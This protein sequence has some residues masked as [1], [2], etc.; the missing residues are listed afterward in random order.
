MA[1]NIEPK[2]VTIGDYLKLERDTKFVIPEYQ[3]EYSWDITTCDKLWSDIIDFIENENNDPYFFG[4]IIINCAKEDTEFGLIDGQQRTTTFMLLLKALLVR[5]NNTLQYMVNDSENEQIKR[6][7]RERRRNLTSILYKVS[8]DEIS[9]EPNDIKDK[10][11]YS[12]FDSVINKSNQET[13]SKELASIMTS[14]NYEEA[15]NNCEKDLSRHKDNRYTNYF[16]N[17]KHFY[18]KTELDKMD[19]LNKIVKTILEKCQ[20]IEIKSWNVEQAITMFNSL[21]SDGMPLTDSDI[22][23]SKMFASTASDGEREKLGKKWKNLIEITKELERNRIANISALLSQKMYLYRSID[24]DTKTANGGTDVT[25][26]GLRRYYTSLKPELIK[27][28]ISFC[29][30]LI[31]LANIWNIVKENTMV[32]VLLV[33][34]DNSKL[35]LASYFHRFDSL[36]TYDEKGEL[37]ITKENKKKI[38]EDT[39]EMS[40]PLLK[41]FTILSLVDYGYSSSSFKTFLFAEEIKMANSNI[42]VEEI[43]K[44]F[45]MHINKTWDKEEIENRIKEYEKNDIVYLNEYLFSKE[46]NKDLII[47][48]DIDIEHIMSQSGKNLQTIQKDAGMEND[49]MFKEYVNK[50]GN[51]ILLEYKINRSIGNEWFRTKVSTTLVDKFGYVNSTYP[52]AKN[53]VEKYANNPKSYWTKDDIDTATDEA[54]ERISKFLFE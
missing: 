48:S 41:L 10:E 38:L 11:I 25:T 2:L 44:D 24:G 1:K 47:G 29:D 35:F 32:K 5:V 45:S 23:Y 4:T 6:A 15:E 53:L 37:T 36:F 43:Q 42:S 28:P 8:T 12:K 39:E 13:H 30:E 16:R 50:V 52:I 9:D 7:L 51:K 26:P 33:F 34:N 31:I 49:E 18:S 40:S 27:N 17:F 19:F 3:R 22:I 46:N 54:A 20:I 14:L 21:N